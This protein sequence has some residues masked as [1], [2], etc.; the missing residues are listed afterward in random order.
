MKKILLLLALFLSNYC[1][2]QKTYLQCGHLID[3]NAGKTLSEMTVVIEGTKI[4]EV[5]TVIK[6]EVKPIKSLT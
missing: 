5:F 1:F 6:M 4:I 3:V 2:A